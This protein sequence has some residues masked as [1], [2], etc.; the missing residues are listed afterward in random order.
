VKQ[1][2]KFAKAQ[3][4]H[5]IAATPEGLVVPMGDHQDALPEPAATDAELS[6][7]LAEL[8][9]SSMTRRPSSHADDPFEVEDIKNR[10]HMPLEQLK[11]M[12]TE[13]PAL[14]AQLI[15]SMLLEERK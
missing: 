4:M 1:I 14:V 10:I 2:A 13:R 6:H 11:K 7:L 12:A 15:K 5:P 3:T 9:G 8:D